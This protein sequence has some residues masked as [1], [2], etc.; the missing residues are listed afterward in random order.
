ML[1]FISLFNAVV[2]LSLFFLSLFAILHPDVNDGIVIKFGLIL[3][4]VGFG[5]LAYKLSGMCGLYEI[6][7]LEKTLL[8]VHSGALVLV[9]GYVLR[10]LKSGHKMQRVSDWFAPKSQSKIQWPQVNGGN[11]G[12]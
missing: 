6:Q 9:I 12:S 5:T 11:D 8:L 2:C 3:L 10:V 7:S 1:E 4:T